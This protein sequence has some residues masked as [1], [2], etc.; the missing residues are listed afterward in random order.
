[1]MQGGGFQ[2]GKRG[3]RGAGEVVG[4]V[5]WGEAQDKA[6]LVDIFITPCICIRI[7]KLVYRAAGEGGGGVLS[8]TAYK[9]RLRHK[10]FLLFQ[11][12]VVTKQH[13]TTKNKNSN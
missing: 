7:C 2:A 13:R 12:T 1:M 10:G 8:L 4:V 9:G 6:V 5:R 11:L 3:R